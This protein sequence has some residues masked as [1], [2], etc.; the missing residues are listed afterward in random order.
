MT[1]RDG[2]TGSTTSANPKSSRQANT[3]ACPGKSTAPT[4][5]ISSSSPSSPTANTRCLPMHPLLQT[6]QEGPLCVSRALPGGALETPVEFL[7]PPRQWAPA[8]LRSGQIRRM[9]H[10]A[11]REQ[12]R[13][14]AVCL[15]P[16]RS[17]HPCVRTT[18]SLPPAWLIPPVLATF[19][20]AANISVRERCGVRRRP[21]SPGSS[22]WF[23]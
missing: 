5:S 6:A 11:C 14:L 7:P 17:A 19:Y 12:T 2:F 23:L 16:R 3:T 10:R 1:R 21:P 8:Q 22:R 13:L 15:S 9:A 20:P 18:K 4:N